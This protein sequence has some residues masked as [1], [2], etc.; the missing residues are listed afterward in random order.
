L[1]DE[2]LAAGAT[3]EIAPKSMPSTVVSTPKLPAAVLAVCEPWPS[4]SSGDR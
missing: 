1:Y 2:T 4:P 3:P